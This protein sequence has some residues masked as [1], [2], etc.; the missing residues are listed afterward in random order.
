MKAAARG[1]RALL[2]LLAQWWRAPGEYRW[3]LGFLKFRGALGALPILTGAGGA[4]LA[5]IVVLVQFGLGGPEGIVGRV[6][7]GMIAGA[8]VAVAWALEWWWAPRPSPRR[9]LVLVA[10]ANAAITVSCV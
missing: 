4:V 8:A 5:V 1:D 6:I 7:D 3:L 10:G 2:Q 9:S